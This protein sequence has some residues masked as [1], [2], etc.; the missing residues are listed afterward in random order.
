MRLQW[1]GLDN[2]RAEAPHALVPARQAGGRAIV[3]EYQAPW[4]PAGSVLAIMGIEVD[5]LK[6]GEDMV[7]VR[8]AG[9][10]CSSR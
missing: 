5:R 4:R 2:V 10:L 3:A 7:L 9:S 1:A 6:A 8:C